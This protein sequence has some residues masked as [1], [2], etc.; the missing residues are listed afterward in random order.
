[1]NPAEESRGVNGY[2]PEQ[3]IGLPPIFSWPLKPIRSIQWLLT[4]FLFPWGFVF[5]GLA[6]I[7]WNYLT[8][9]IGETGGLSI[10]FVGLIFLRNCCLLVV[11]AGGLHWWLYRKARQ[12]SDYKFSKR[13]M[14][15]TSPRFLWRNQVY[16]NVFWSLASGVSV[17]SAFEALTLWAW[18]KGVIPQA[19]WTGDFLYLT[20][21]TVVFFFASSS[22][23]Y[24]IHRM[25]HWSP[26]YRSVHELHHRNVNTGPWTGIS[27]HPVEHLM[28]FSMFFVWWL[29][30]THPTIIIL[31][32]FFKGLGPAVSHS[33][34]C[35]IR[36][37]RRSLAA[38]DWFHDLHHR[39]FE[40]NY[41]NVEAPFD[42]ARGT[43]H[44]GSEVAK[45]E[46][47]RRRIAQNSTGIDGHAE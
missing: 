20:C 19:H 29:V 46:M 16:D 40:V 34:F 36:M 32:G 39:H 28:F 38:G 6:A 26:L 14:S 45:K 37:G 5:I 23:F 13:W 43:W 31:T 7:S 42:W 9:N 15:R 41:G 27:M 22:H 18:M 21:S 25:L 47:V 24:L 10:G 1:M 33:G 12:G 44:D 8:P 17:W 11:V 30:P 35:K 2:R 4:E 3:P